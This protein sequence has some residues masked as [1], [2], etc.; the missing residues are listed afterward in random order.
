MSR[1][2]CLTRV[3]TFM[4]ALEI[5]SRTDLLSGV[6]DPHHAAS[7]HL[8]HANKMALYG[9]MNAYHMQTF[10]YFLEKLRSTPD[11]D[12]S[13][14]DHSMIMFGTGISNGDR[15]TH[16]N[17]P[18]L[19]V[20]GGAGQI[21]GGRH[22]QYPEGT[23]LANLHVT[24]LD[25]LGI[26]GAGYTALHRTADDWGTSLTGVFGITARSTEWGD[27]AP[28]AAAWGSGRSPV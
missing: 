1:N 6:P 20:G 22:L 9:R 15:H 26:P 17:L 24:V 14:L 23:P 11:G 4:L 13:L 25:K 27:G 7:H 2:A 5:S 12:G 21:K 3:F 8:G 16:D 19:L 28:R 10:N 18:I